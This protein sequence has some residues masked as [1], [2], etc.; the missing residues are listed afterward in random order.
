MGCDGTDTL[1]TG[2]ANV[3]MTQD[4]QHSTHQTPK[5]NNSIKDHWHYQMRSATK[6]A[7]SVGC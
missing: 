6:K 3:K 2:I 5:K 1:P 4:L 7:N